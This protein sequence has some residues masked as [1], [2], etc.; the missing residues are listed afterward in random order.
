MSSAERVLYDR[1][2]VESFIPQ[3]DP[4]LFVDEIRAFEPF[5]WVRSVKHLSGDEHFFGGHFPDQPVMPGVLL[6]ENIAQT[7]NFLVACSHEAPVADGGPRMVFGMVN[8]ARFLKPVLP[9]VDLETEATVVK[10]LS[11]S[12]IV[13]GVVRVAGE[14]VCSAKLQF[15]AIG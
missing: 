7:A 12:G 10:L 4:F 8:R 15:G 11:R 13:D 9:P 5:K 1:Q 2:A 14:D 3:R 6:L